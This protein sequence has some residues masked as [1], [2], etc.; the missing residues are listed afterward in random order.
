MAF[1]PLGG[2]PF[3]KDQIA[4]AIAHSPFRSGHTGIAFHSV[5]HGP[6]VLHLAWHKRLDVEAIPTELK[7]CWVADPLPTPPSASKQVVAI[8]R[9][10]ATRLPEINYA[11]DF[12]AAKGSFD[13]NGAYK[14]P[15]GS[16]G[17]TCASFVVEVLRGCR[18][19]LVK[20]DTWQSSE[21]NVFWA[22][23]ICDH[24]ATTDAAHA[25]A[26]RKNINGLRLTPFE[27]A[28]ASVSGPKTWPLDFNTARQYAPAVISALCKLCPPPAGMYA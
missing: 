11:T 1:S 8:V 28:G 22:N 20:E 4:I 19:N 13:N 7:A 15:K 10:V 16:K 21:E 9:S 2:I 27:V 23:A 25:E 6:Q 14:P 12:I 18:I 26:V 17:L 5:K 24:L 3:S